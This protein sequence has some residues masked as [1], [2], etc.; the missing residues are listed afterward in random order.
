MLNIA[1]LE[2]RFSAMQAACCE[3]L[4]YPSNRKPTVEKRFFRKPDQLRWVGLCEHSF[5][6]PRECCL[7]LNVQCPEVT[8]S[9]SIVR[10]AA[11]EAVVQQVTLLSRRAGLALVRADSPPTCVRLLPDLVSV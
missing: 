9:S 5:E 11:T 10:M 1:W 2:V 3:W 8:R 6:R 4:S 7:H